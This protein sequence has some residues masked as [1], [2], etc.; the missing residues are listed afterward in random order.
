MGDRE[1]LEVGSQTVIFGNSEAMPEIGTGTIDVVFTSPPYWKR[2]DYEHP[3]QI[4][5]DSYEEY[6][7]RLD[8]V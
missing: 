1:T 8:A 2:K 7:S 6:L 3:S 4:G 5:Q